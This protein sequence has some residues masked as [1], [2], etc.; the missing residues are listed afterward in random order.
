MKRIIIVIC[1]IATTLTFTGCF[2]GKSATSSGRGGEV[3]GVGGG[4]GF[5][6]PTPYGM[7]MIKRG[8][9]RMG[10]DKQDSLWGKETPV[11]DI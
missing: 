3:T 8:F 1:V 10:I 6:E 2:G 5:S 9:L 7:T 4:K 11:K